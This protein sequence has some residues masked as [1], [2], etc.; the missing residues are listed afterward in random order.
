MFV[1]RVYRPDKRWPWYTL[2]ALEFPFTVALLAL[3]G[4][5]DPNTYRTKL[6][7][8]GAANGFNSSPE[9]GLYAAANYRPY[10]TPG[11]WSQLYGHPRSHP[12]PGIL[13]MSLAVSQVTI[14][15]S[16]FWQHLS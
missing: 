16:Q 7:A 10:T 1:S 6:W 2:L 9:T 3:F 14:L 4:I 11:V 5:A 8:D 12:Y 13:L 15:S